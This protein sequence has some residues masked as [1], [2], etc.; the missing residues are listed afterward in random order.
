V[1]L[2]ILVSR[3]ADREE[4]QTQVGERVKRWFRRSATVKQ[5]LAALK[6]SNGR[7]GVRDDVTGATTWLQE[8]DTIGEKDP[9]GWATWIIEDRRPVQPVETVWN[10]TLVDAGGGS[11]PVPAH[12]GSDSEGGEPPEEEEEE[13]E[14]KDEEESWGES[15]VGQMWPGVTAIPT[16]AGMKGAVDEVFRALGQRPPEDRE[17][18]EAVRAWL[19][20]RVV[21]AEEDA[22]EGVVADFRL[23]NFYPRFPDHEYPFAMLILRSRGLDVDVVGRVVHKYVD[24]CVKNAGGKVRTWEWRPRG[25]AAGTRL[26]QG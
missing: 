3:R 14:D 26:A 24:R 20:S 19:N 22:W 17:I 7:V 2:R 9:D 1:Q 10:A 15:W 8:G 23:L 18:D 16:D 6:V 25:A 13:E 11:L 5:I 12:A 21:S 4:E